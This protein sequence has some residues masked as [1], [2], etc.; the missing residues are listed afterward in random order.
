MAAPKRYGR[1]TG[2]ALLG[3]SLLVAA[4]VVAGPAQADDTSF[5]NDVHNAGNA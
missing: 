5:L 1:L 2:T 3:G 4:V